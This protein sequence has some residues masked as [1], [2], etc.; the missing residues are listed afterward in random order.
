ML[1]IE[2]DNTELHIG[3]QLRRMLQE[4]ANVNSAGAVS[5]QGN[6]RPMAYGPT[7]CEFGPKPPTTLDVFFVV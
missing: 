5:H 1:G 4:V 7:V 3:G 6:P 2:Q